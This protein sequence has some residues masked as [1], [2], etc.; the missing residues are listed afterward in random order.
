MKKY[1]MK[2]TE[3]ELQ[4]GDMIELN[5]VK[6]EKGHRTHSH[7]ECKFIPELVD[8]LLENDVIDVKE[9]EDEEEEDCLEFADDDT[10]VIDDMLEDIE[11]MDKRIEAIEDKVKNFGKVL[12]KIYDKVTAMTE[13]DKPQKSQ[14]AKK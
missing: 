12:D 8:T 7:L 13:I 10:C 4:F 9:V 2:D 5:L 11:N 1:F 6:E 3:D 14:K